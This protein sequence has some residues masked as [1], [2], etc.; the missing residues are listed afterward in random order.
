MIHDNAKKCK[1]YPVSLHKHCLI[2]SEANLKGGLARLIKNVD[3]HKK[4]KKRSSVKLRL[5]IIL[6]K[7]WET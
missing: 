6:Q 2:S 1:G 3:K 7:K 4:E 5:F